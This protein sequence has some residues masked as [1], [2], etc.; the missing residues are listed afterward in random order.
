MADLSALKSIVGP[1]GWSEDPAMLTPL[2]IEPRGLFRGATPLLLRPETTAQVA[3]IVAECRRAGIALV[4]QGG[5]TGLCG[6]ATPDPSGSQVLISL[7][8]MNRVRA[9]DP[10]DYTITVEAGCILQHI[11]QAAAAVDRL[12]PLSLGAEGSCT[13]G[14]NL[15]TNAG[16]INTLRFGNARDLA[17][18][19]EV[20]LPDGRLWDGLRLLR[21]DN[22]GYDLKHLFIGA[23]GS[24][25]IITAATLKLFPRPREEVNAIVA[26]RD[27]PGVLELLSRLR[28]ATGDQITA[29]EFMERFGIDLAIKHVPGVR[30]PLDRVHAHY[31]LVRGS[32][33]RENSGLREC[34]EE[35]LAA[36][37]EEG[38][39][40]DAAIAESEQQA[41]DFWRIREGIVEGQIPEGGSIKHDISVPVS[42]VATFIALADVA[43]AKAIPGCRPCAFGHAG[44]GNIHYNVTQPVDMNRQEYLGRWKEL[45]AVVHP[46]VL[47]LGGSISAEHGIGQLKRGELAE[48]K[49]PVEMD[50]MRA[51]KQ[52]LDPDGLMNPGKVV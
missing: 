50:L 15:S 46:I 40:L 43:V 45:N 52:V 27:V 37:M 11:Q 12:F 20:V 9:I 31:A 38:L 47:S 34:M 8:R 3:A 13:I 6:G 32:A 25:G 29:F 19:L 24:L 5:N 26:V 49:S 18:G 33:G 4:P 1:K 2:L 44:D 7:G 41:R 14:G 36:A 39:V 35:T 23:E 42:K 21:K 16:G 17:L 30:D 28:L 22:T 51:I 48:V 10:L